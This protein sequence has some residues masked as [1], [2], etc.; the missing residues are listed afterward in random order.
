MD[1]NI[2]G[3][4]ATVNSIQYKNEKVFVN[5]N[6]VVI[7]ITQPDG[8]GT[9]E[10]D[11]GDIIEF[12]SQNKLPRNKSVKDHLA[13]ASG[14][15]KYSFNLKPGE[16]KKVFVVVPFHGAKK[17][18][19]KFNNL[20]NTEKYFADKL[21]ENKNY[22]RRKLNFSTFDLPE[23]GT[24][25]VN[26]FKSNLAYILINKDGVA[27]QPGSRCYERSWIRDGAISASALM[28]FGMIKEARNYIDWYSQ[29]QYANGKIPCVV[30]TRGPDPV[31]EHDSHGEYI[32]LVHEIFKFTKDTTYLRGKFPSVVKA[33]DYINSLIAERSTDEYKIVDSLKHLFGLL[34]ESISHEGYSAKP[35]H[36]YWDDFWALKGFKVAV[37][38]A[39]IL[40][41]KG[42]VTK[43][44]KERDEFRK[45]FYN[46]IELSANKHKINY[47]PGCADLGDF[48]AT[49]TTIALFPCGE[50]EYLPKDKLKNTFDKYYKHFTAR[51]DSV[52]L[53][54][55]NYTPYEIRATGSFIYMGQPEKAKEMLDY[56]FKDQHPYNWN[57][58]A[59]V[60]WQDYRSPRYVGDMPHTWIGSDFVNVFRAMFVYENDNTNSLVVGAGLYKDWIDAPSGMS[61]ENLSTFYGSLS[62]SIKKSGNEYKV[63]LKGNVEVPSG[64]IILENFHGSKLPK[65]VTINGKA[66]TE[67][68]NSKIFITEF[69]ANVIIAY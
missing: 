40:N 38:M 20:V 16:V 8:F 61:V 44:S 57:H 49:S 15:L 41:E 27:T 64:K 21:E 11:E 67:F 31:P 29:Y 45:N 3:G 53:N 30:D 42:Y 69:P 39:A 68:T 62:Y 66:S 56:F 51:R 54:W 26:T 55:T 14:S 6:K 10:F 12:I 47:I 32:Y 24:K 5:E 36:S 2:L 22:W 25:L 18:F 23:S 17:E 50:K 46:S 7:P 43:F 1:L 28:K 60:V 58:W 4:A 48:D 37:D 35:M 19:K 34:T 59:E 63:D 33:I 13:Y 65:S 52:G 9:V